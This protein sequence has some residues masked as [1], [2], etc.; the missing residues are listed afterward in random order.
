MLN[1]WAVSLLARALNSLLPLAAL[2]L[3]LAP[4]VTPVDA[5]ATVHAARNATPAAHGAPA[6]ALDGLA[7]VELER[8][9][10]P[11]STAPPPTRDRSITR[12]STS[13]PDPTVVAR[14]R[15]PIYRVRRSGQ[16][17]RSAP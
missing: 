10:D 16:A 11:P 4:Q 3:W 7:E 1:L 5:A 12:A 13:T 14:T 15:G 2:A 9:L 17:H 6:V 8:R